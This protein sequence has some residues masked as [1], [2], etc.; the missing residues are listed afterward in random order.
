VT[1]RVLIGKL[2]EHGCHSVRQSGS[3]QIWRCG[4][5]QTVVPV[6]AGDLTPGMLRSIVRDLAPCLGA[7]WLTT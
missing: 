7:N 4:N 6:H 3:H 5:C 2:R 1:A